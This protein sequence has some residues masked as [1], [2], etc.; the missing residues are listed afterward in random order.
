VKNIY[1]AMNSLSSLVNRIL[2]WISGLL[3]ALCAAALLFQVL[4]RFVIV[5][6]FSFSFPFTE[7]FARFALIWSCYLCLGMCL[8]EGSQASVNFLYD[9]LRGTPKLLL[10]LLTRALM[11]LFLA[12][13]VYYG[14]IITG[15]NAIF[16]SATLRIPGTYLYSAPVLGCILMAYETVT[17]ILGVLCGELKPFGAG[18]WDADQDD[19]GIDVD[20]LAGEYAERK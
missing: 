18:A 7:E 4:Y 17:E 14:I 5:K 13:A 19:A 16:R 3:I 20:K 10:Y 1:H 11:L 6:I 12:V 9:R 15:N 2:G 8:K